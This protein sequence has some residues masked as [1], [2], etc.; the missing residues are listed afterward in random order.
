MFSGKKTLANLVMLSS[1][2]LLAGCGSSNTSSTGTFSLGIT[3]GP[4]D[5]ATKVV[6][7]FTGV[8][9]KPADGEALVF[10]FETPKSIDLLQ[11]Q[12]TASDGLLTDEVVASGNYEWIRLHV[13]ATQD[14][15]MDSYMEMNDGS[16]IELYVPSGGQTGLKLVNGFTIAAGGSADFTIDFDLR[17]SITNPGGMPSAIL[18][19]ALRIVDNTVVGSIEGTIEE[20]LV[21]QQCADA[22][23]DDGSV[24]VYTG[25]DVTPMDIQGT[26]G[27]PLVTALVSFVDGA[28]RYEL[29][30]LPEGDYT[31]AYTCA[32]ASDD[33]ATADTLQ[34]VGAATVP[35][36]AEMASSH[37]F[38]VTVTAD[39]VVQ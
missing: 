39:V 30:F 16:M 5:S 11:L 32:A 22:T 21:G 15:V 17:K 33:P 19:P 27:D 3:D 20:T 34:F 10:D 26:S 9:I 6:V 2:G 13:N 23:V 38:S 24:Y 1:M 35:V 8:S 7:E 28:Y 14:D 36:L 29:G 12:G 18:K 25:A 31:V 4:V 37:D